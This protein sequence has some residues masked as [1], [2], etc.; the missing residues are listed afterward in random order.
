MSTPG[1]GSS[2]QLLER[3]RGGDE[4][5]LNEL[6]NRYLP[7]LRRWARGR[8]PRGARDVADTD[9]I[10][11]ETMIATLRNLG[12]ID[13]EREGALQAYL[14]QA[15]TNRMVD[16][17]RR[18]QRRPSETPADS[19][20]PA[21]DHASPLEAAIGEEAVRRYDLGLKKLR[22]EE[23]EAV[24]LRVE[25][26][27]EYAQIADM[28]GKPTADAARVAVSRALARLSREMK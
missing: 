28:L 17:F 6:L 12:Q 5:A 7:R 10:V 15:L 8:L 16:A 23:R 18:A 20:L 4:S 27:Y 24:I 13:V 14:R 9:D 26:C 3:A 2:V 1:A 22:A 25:L 11:Q 19:D 21:G